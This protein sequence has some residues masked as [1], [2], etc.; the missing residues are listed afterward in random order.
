MVYNRPAL[1]L[2]HRELIFLCFAFFSFVSGE[3]ILSYSCSWEIPRFE[4]WRLSPLLSLSG[5]SLFSVNMSINRPLRAWIS[6]CMLFW[7]NAQK[8]WPRFFHCFRQ[9]TCVPGKRLESSLFCRSLAF[10]EG[11]KGLH[12]VT[13]QP[14]CKNRVFSGSH[15]FLS[16]DTLILLLGIESLESGVV[17]VCIGFSNRSSTRILGYPGPVG[18]SVGRW[19]SAARRSAVLWC[20][21]QLI[22]ERSLLASLRCLFAAAYACVTT[23]FPHI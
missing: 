21:A 17:L 11:T 7:A 2:R 10:N 9:C 15:I 4:R 23:G 8:C 20:S 13:R 14:S 5:S 6:E 3:G 18:L 16:G 22:P 12:V 19:Q 1:E